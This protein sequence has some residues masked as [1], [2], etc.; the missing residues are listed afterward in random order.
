MNKTPKNPVLNKVDERKEK[1]VKAKPSH[2]TPPV[3]EA[4]GASDEQQSGIP[5]KAT[6]SGCRE[7]FSLVFTRRGGRSISP[8]DVFLGCDGKPVYS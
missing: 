6:R 2:P 4:E 8:D 5:S 1:A 3:T 7:P